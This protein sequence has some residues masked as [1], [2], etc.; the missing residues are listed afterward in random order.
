MCYHLTSFTQTTVVYSGLWV[1]S[2]A[3]IQDCSWRNWAWCHKE[4]WQTVLP[5]ILSISIQIANTNA[6]FTQIQWYSSL[7][8]PLTTSVKWWRLISQ[9]VQSTRMYL[10]WVKYLWLHSLSINWLNCFS[11]W[12][13]L[14]KMSFHGKMKRDGCCFAVSEAIPSWICLYLWKHIQSK[15]Y[16]LGRMKYSCLGTSW[17]YSFYS[18]SPKSVVL[19]CT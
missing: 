13:S 8:W 10:R 12:S 6:L 18:S 17:R 9:M 14:P 4:G 19:I 5:L 3:F 7:A 11:N 16:W 2:M 15:Q 1:L